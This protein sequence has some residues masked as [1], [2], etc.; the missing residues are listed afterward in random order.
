MI[1]LKEVKTRIID[2]IR[3]DPA[4]FRKPESLDMEIQSGFFPVWIVE[5]A[6]HCSWYGKYAESRT[7]TKFRDAAKGGMQIQEPYSEIETSWHPCTG[8]HDFT[9]VFKMQANGSSVRDYNFLIRGFDLAKTRSGFPPP[10]LKCSVQPTTV[11]QREAWDKNRCSA[12]IDDRA[13]K[14][15]QTQAEQLDKVSTKLESVGFTLVFLPFATIEYS[16]NKRKYRHL[17]DLVDGAFSGDMIALDHALVDAEK[18]SSEARNAHSKQKD[19]DKQTAESKEKLRGWRKKTFSP[20]YNW[21]FGF[22]APLLLFFI[23]VI[24]GNSIAWVFFGLVLVAMIITYI[25]VFRQASSRYEAMKRKI[26][27]TLPKDTPW[28]TF[29]KK[30]RL[31]LIRMRRILEDQKVLSELPPDEAKSHIPRMQKLRQLEGVD[32]EESFHEAELMARTL[33]EGPDTLNSKQ[34]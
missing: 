28:R 12:S 5:A 2:E 32:S 13:K 25:I 18:L 31:D 34:G 9:A 33:C 30:Y 6:I 17:F 24:T 20:V 19:I 15:C 10:T 22:I 3:R 11:T 26:E 7:V 14:E 23:A 1:S 27:A 29:V 8:G 16:A 4:G 21:A